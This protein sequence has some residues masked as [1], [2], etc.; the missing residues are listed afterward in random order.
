M[1]YPPMSWDVMSIADLWLA[2]SR[3]RA[4]AKSGRTQGVLSVSMGAVRD[5]RVG[6]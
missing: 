6:I 5:A 1:T 4:Q 2:L 3:S